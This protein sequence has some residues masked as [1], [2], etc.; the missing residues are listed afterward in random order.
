MGLG[1]AI[2]Y[3]T[4]MGYTVAVPLTDSQDYDLIVDDGKLSRV[5]VRTT[6]VVTRHGHPRVNLRVLGGNQSWNRVSKLFDAT[7]VEYLFV[8]VP[9]GRMW[10]I[11]TTFTNT[12]HLNLG[13]RM[14]QYLI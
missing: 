7:K 1:A 2:G 9:D 13:P 12:T 10:C 14:N 6:S 8:V 11:P 5:Q 4:R 3:F